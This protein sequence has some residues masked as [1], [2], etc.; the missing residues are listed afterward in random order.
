MRLDRC[1]LGKLFL[2]LGTFD[3]NLATKMSR[4]QD[5]MGHLIKFDFKFIDK[6]TSDDEIFI[7]EKL[8]KG[9]N[10]QVCLT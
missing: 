9:P 8:N 3:R 4:D 6:L 7:F 5:S 1:V 2:E 10:T